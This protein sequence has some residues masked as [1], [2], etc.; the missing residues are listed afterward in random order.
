MSNETAAR[1]DAWFKEYETLRQESL[2]S[3]G[4]RTQI[5]SFGLGTLAVLVGGTIAASVPSPQL[6]RT[7]FDAAIPIISVLI[8]YA[9]FAEFERMVR[10][11]RFIQRLEQRI[12]ETLGS[13]PVLSWEK[14]VETTRMGYAYVVVAVLFLGIAAVAPYAGLLVQQK[15]DTVAEGLLRLPADL[16]LNSLIAE[17]LIAWMA[18]LFAVVHT[19][20]R[21]L[22]VLPKY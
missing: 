9:W 6:V 7:M 17:S 21:F 12:N 8:Y 1:R 10:A 16:S 3:M 11:G 14:Y 5:I 20:S 2:Q 4:N 19:G 13:E 15:T 18:V 22:R